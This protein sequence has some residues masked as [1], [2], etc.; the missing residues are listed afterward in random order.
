MICIGYLGVEAFDIILYIG[1]TISKLKYPV[2]IVDLSDT[3]ALTKAI[4]HG[5]DL[6]STEEIVHY[7]NLNYIRRLPQ[8]NELKDFNEGVVF[9]VFG[10]NYINTHPIKLDIINIVADPFPNH[11]NKINVL[12][13]DI[14]LDKQLRLIIRDII[15]L[16][17]LERTKNS[18]IFSNKPV[19]VKY[20]YLDI[21]DYEN[22]IQCQRIQ[23][24]R[25]KRIS[26]RMKKLIVNEIA[27]TIPNIKPSKIR[28][29]VSTARKG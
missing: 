4:Y 23:I 1:Q 11:I 22:A 2:L 15:T 17:D 10:F 7:R 3:G 27:H 29:A 9:V 21:A 24:V 8:E 28:R 12:I 6:Y 13:K 25:F 14:P 20:L 16:D 19:P 18:L 5:M 26:S